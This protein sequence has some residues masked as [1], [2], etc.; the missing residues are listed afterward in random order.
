MEN[1][2]IEKYITGILK[3]VPPQQLWHFFENEL[4]SFTVALVHFSDQNSQNYLFN[5]HVI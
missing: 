1:R 5:L 4:Q 3:F 2:I